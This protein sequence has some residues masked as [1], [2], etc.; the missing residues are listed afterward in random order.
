MK[1]LTAILL[2][3]VMVLSLSACGGKA[4]EMGENEITKLLDDGYYSV[5]TDVGETEYRGLFMKGDDS[6]TAAYIRV[7]APM[8]DKLYQEYN[9]ISWE[10]EQ[11]EEKQ[12]AVLSRLTDVAVTDVTDRIPTQAELDGYV[13]KTMGD[14]ENDGF[15]HSGWTGDPGEGY[16]FYYDGPL[17]YC[18]VIPVGSMEITDMD[19]YS[20]NDIRAMEVE[21]IEFMGFSGGILDE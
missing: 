13:G 17:Y 2:A 14:M 1:K 5:M 4:G 9:N 11:C 20:E 19:D 21:S 12:L 3:L 7:S 10:D 6:A 15:Y 8:T 18:R 16:S